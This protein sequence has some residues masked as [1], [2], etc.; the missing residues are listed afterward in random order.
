MINAL[1]TQNATQMIASLSSTV[2]RGFDQVQLTQDQS[3]Q[4]RSL[5]A[6]VKESYAVPLMNAFQPLALTILTNDS[7]A[8]IAK[9]SNTVSKDAID[10]SSRL[11]LEFTDFT[12]GFTQDWLKENSVDLSQKYPGLARGKS[13]LGQS[14]SN[15]L[16]Q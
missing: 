3:D 11:T 15:S 12:L 10:M 9:R 14:L 13:P 1:N 5:H 7:F 8:S 2:L 6:F 4:D 16:M